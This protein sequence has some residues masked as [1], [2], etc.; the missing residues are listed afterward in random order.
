MRSASKA[1]LDLMMNKPGILV[2]PA[3]IDRVICI[4]NINLSLV[5][6]SMTMEH[7]KANNQAYKPYSLGRSYHTYKAHLTQKWSVT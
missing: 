1:E 7:G 2:I 4:D 5:S 3:L 6:L